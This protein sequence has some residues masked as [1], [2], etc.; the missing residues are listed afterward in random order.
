MTIHLRNLGRI[1]K[2]SIYLSMS[3]VKKIISLEHEC[4]Y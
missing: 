4:F 2:L 3:N 1:L